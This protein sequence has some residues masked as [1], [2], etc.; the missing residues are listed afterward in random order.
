MF[1]RLSKRFNSVT[2]ARIGALI[3][4]VTGLLKLSDFV[5]GYSHEARNVVFPFVSDQA[6]LSC[7]MLIELAVAFFVLKAARFQIKYAMYAL[8]W[9]STLFLLYRV[10][11]AWTAPHHGCLCA[12]AGLLFL[13]LQPLP[14]KWITTFLLGY[15]L[16]VSYGWFMGT[17]L[18]RFFDSKNSK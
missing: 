16:C 8:A 6:I 3:L 10:A 18:L 2:L 15:L 12:G 11:L 4:L 5:L 14:V 1:Q 17:S 9:I 13:W 7:A